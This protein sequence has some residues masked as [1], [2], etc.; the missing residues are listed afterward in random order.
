MTGITL[1]QVNKSFGPIHVLK[2]IN[3]QFGA[4]EFVV[5]VGP[6][7]CGKST[8]LRMIAGLE[9]ISSGD[10]LFGDER[11]NDLEPRERDI[12]MVFQ[13]YALYPHMSVER[14]LGFSLEIRKRELAEKKEKT[15]KASGILGLNQLLDRLPKALSGGQRQRVAMGRAIVRDPQIFLFDEPLSNLDASLRIEMRIE[16][17][18]LHHKL[19]TTMVYVT[20]D[21]VEAMTLADRIVVMNAGRVEQ[22]GSPLELYKNPT[23]LFVA[24]FLGS[25]KMNFVDH[26]DKALNLPKA[27]LHPDAKTYG[28]RPEHVSVTNADKAAH[29]VGTIE[30]VERLGSDT[31]FYLN[32]GAQNPFVVRVAGID[33]TNV[34]EKIGVVFQQDNLHRFDQSSN[35]ITA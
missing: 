24:G 3:L 9:T 7:G 10:L 12:A 35:A 26:E 33:E 4:G 30:V 11:V 8:L 27:S 29:L 23:N 1:N 34:G 14:N 6:S 5:L 25:P 32:H 13:S 31:M 28:I 19:K 16:I 15:A 18:K 2:D 22:V 17:A 20:H 21:Q